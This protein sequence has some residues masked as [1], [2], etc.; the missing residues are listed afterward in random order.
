M[1]KPIITWQPK[2]FDLKTGKRPTHFVTNFSVDPFDSV[3]KVVIQKGLTVNTIS[4]TME[5]AQ[6][7]GLINLSTLKHLL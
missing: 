4:M 2:S 1:D 5:R 3:V 6:E 7:I